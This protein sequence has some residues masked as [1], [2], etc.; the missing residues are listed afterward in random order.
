M[1]G[2]DGRTGGKHTDVGEGTALAAED[3]NT[4]ADYGSDTELML[5]AMRAL[6]KD[7]EAPS[8]REKGFQGMDAYAV[9]FS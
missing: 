1:Q 6:R 2:A 9:L 4:A 8:A 5:T 7:K 3:E